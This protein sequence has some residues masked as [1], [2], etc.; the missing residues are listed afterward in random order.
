MRNISINKLKKKLNDLRTKPPRLGVHPTKVFKDKTKYTKLSIQEKRSIKKMSKIKVSYTANEKFQVSPRSYYLHY[1]R[2]LREEVV[3]SALPFGSVFDTA[4]GTLLMERDLEKS[5]SIFTKLW[6][7][8]QINGK[9]ENMSTTNKVRWSKSD[10]DE[11]ILTEEDK[12]LISKGKANQAWVSM[13]RKGI[14]MLEAYSEQ[15]LPHLKKVVSTQGYVKIENEEGD[16]IRGYIDLI[17]EWELNKEV[18]VSYKDTDLNL[19]KSLLEL[20]K[21]NGEIVVFDNKTAS[22]K[23]KED[24]VR[25]SRQLG[26]YIQ[27]TNIPEEVKYAGYI[28]VPKKFRKNKLPKIPIQVIIDDIPKEIIEDI[29]DEY[30]DTIKG[31][32]LGEFP[33]TG[34][35]KKTPWGCCY[36]KFCE[37]EGQDT[38]GLIYV[39]KD[40]DNGKKS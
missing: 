26:T 33:C 24:S 22:Q 23:Y 12:A 10:Y 21:Y 11:N 1:L 5:K 2:K 7:S 29:F 36:K 28:V 30:E 40:I 39:G 38:T 4:Q 34:D 14:L 6:K 18:A 19:T 32:K 31:I 13:H 9:W 8:Q 37:S 16:L 20:E 27:D 35:C 25:T 15:V 3:G 17:A